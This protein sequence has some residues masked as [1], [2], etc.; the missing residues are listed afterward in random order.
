MIERVRRHAVLVSGLDTRWDPAMAS[1]LRKELASLTPPEKL[2]RSG[3]TS[4][5]RAAY[6]LTLLAPLRGDGG[7]GRAVKT[8]LAGGP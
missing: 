8:A 1:Y 7:T 3:L 5:E 2:H 4:E 6:A